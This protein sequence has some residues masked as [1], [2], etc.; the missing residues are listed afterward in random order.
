[1]SSRT[2]EILRICVFQEVS[3]KHYEFH[4]ASYI[5]LPVAD[6]SVMPEAEVFQFTQTLAKAGRD[7]ERLLVCST[8]TPCVEAS[9]GKVYTIGH[10]RPQLSPHSGK[11][12][13]DA[14]LGSN[15][16]ATFHLEAMALGEKKGELPV[17]R[18]A[19][20]W[21]HPRSTA[22]LRQAVSAVLAKH[23]LTQC[24]RQVVYEQPRHTAMF[25]VALAYLTEAEYRSDGPLSL[26]KPA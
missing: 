14:R 21:P 4:D 24:L 13:N 26:L 9:H 25:H 22:A 10:G 7:N 6:N 12:V 3:S 1:M 17:V 23:I 11:P 2:A 8:C 16:V 19:R 20:G 18:T 15:S 5:A